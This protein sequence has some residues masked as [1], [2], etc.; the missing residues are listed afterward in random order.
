MRNMIKWRNNSGISL[1]TL[2]ITI[3]VII[4]LSSIVI[5]SQFTTTNSASFSKFVQEYEEVFKSVETIRLGD[6]KSDINNIDNQFIKVYV[7]G[8]VP[9][10]FKSLDG[11]SSKKQGYLVNL[12]VIGCDELITGREYKKFI[13]SGDFITFGKD[14]VYVYDARGVLY[15]AKG[16]LYDGNMYYEGVTVNN[17]EIKII[18]IAKKQM[19]S[20]VKVTITVESENEIENVTVGGKNASAVEDGKYEILIDRDV[21]DSK[22]YDVI[23][24]DEKGKQAR[25]IVTIPGIGATSENGPDIE[26]EVTN[27]TYENGTYNITGNTAKLKITSDTA[28]DLFISMDNSKPTEWLPFSENVERYFSSSGNYKLYVW[29][30]DGNGITNIS[31]YELSIKVDMKST[32]P[33]EPKDTIENGS[34]I[35]AAIPDNDTW[36][37]SKVVKINFSDNRQANGYTSSYAIENPFGNPKWKNSYTS[38]ATTEPITKSGTKVFAKITFKSDYTNETLIYPEPNSGKEYE[39]YMVEKIDTTPPNIQSL[40]FI[41]EKE[42]NNFYIQ[43]QA[44]DTESGAV[45]EGGNVT[46]LALQNGLDFNVIDPNTKTWSTNGKIQIS[47]AGRWFFYAKDPVGNVSMKTLSFDLPDNS[48]PI[49]DSIIV[50]PSNNSLT[51]KLVAHDNI[52]IVGYTMIKDNASEPTTWTGI[53]ETQQ[54]AVD[55]NFSESGKYYVWVIDAAGNK[56]MDTIEAKT[57]K[58][59]KLDSDYPL[60]A[61]VNEGQQAVFSIRIKEDGYPDEYT[62]SW[63]VSKDNGSTWEAIDNANTPTYIKNNTIADEDGYIYKCLV[64]NNS[65]TVESNIAKLEVVGI[66]SDKPSSIQVTPDKEMV[67]GGITINNGAT[68]TASSTLTIQIFAINAYE[69]SISEN[70]S[71]SNSWQ[72]YQNTVTYQLNNKD[73]GIKTISVWIRD[74]NGNELNKV[75]SAQIRKID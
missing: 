52:G 35:M 65:G 1:V 23:V 36:S 37:K 19:D 70:G 38:E 63:K 56:T 74:E 60:T 24:K 42:V 6:T 59:P 25:S 14:D 45:S 50:I 62:Y 57:Y 58:L 9:F 51:I 47:E 8:D 7:S 26:A 4:I 75:V 10:S 66:T 54:I 48:E 33:T 34:I 3:V 46:Y 5:Y 64:T 41:S 20:I 21:K 30:R 32:R 12:N 43:G 69:Y 29:A 53:T 71:K 15:Y 17:S 18:D 13:S 55:Q 67:L 72:R 68:T 28:K 11:I 49:I 16:Y 27:G 31:P 61:H 39:T 44:V 2:V 40:E 73:N 22:N